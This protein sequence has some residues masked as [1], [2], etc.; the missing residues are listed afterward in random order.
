MLGAG[1]LNHY[2]RCSHCC[3]VVLRC[4]AHVVSQIS[5]GLRKAL[6]G[7][8]K[9]VVNATGGGGAELLV[10]GAC[11][12]GFTAAPDQNGFGAVCLPCHSLLCAPPAVVLAVWVA[13]PPR[14]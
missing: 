4:A 8:N 6:G 10:Q 14:A 5:A 9:D 12:A 13:V 1:V 7:E 3:C 11:L 2:V